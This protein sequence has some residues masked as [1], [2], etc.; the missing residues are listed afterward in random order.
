MTFFISEKSTLTSSE[1]LGMLVHVPKCGG[2]AIQKFIQDQGPLL[3]RPYPSMNHHRSLAE[4]LLFATRLGA[5]LDFV[6]I[7]W[8][9]PLEWRL[10]I[11]NYAK[12]QSP[13]VSFMPFENYFFKTISFEDYLQ[14]LLESD[15]WKSPRNLS[16]SEL[17]WNALWTWL[18]TLQNCSNIPRRVYLVNASRNVY[19][20]IG[21]ILSD[22]FPEHD[23]QNHNDSTQEIN[24]F[25]KA[26]ERN[27]VI[28]NLPPAMRKCLVSYDMG[29]LLDYLSFR[30][31]MQCFEGSAWLNRWSEF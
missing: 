30:Q 18:I 7:P 8:R 4:S 23:R 5:Q 2:S 14:M 27:L 10:S 26:E 25:T 28:S 13:D 3:T 1:R 11:Y 31:D 29:K 16:R 20:A 15:P 6:I 12:R 22:E 19:T 9:N 24:V 21:R 17:P